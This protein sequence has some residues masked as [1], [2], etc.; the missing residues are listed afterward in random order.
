MPE[1]FRD[2]D[3][4]AVL[5]P[6]AADG[7]RISSACFRR[8][9]PH[10]GL[11]DLRPA[12]EWE[13]SVCSRLPVVEVRHIPLRRVF[14]DHADARTAIAC[15]VDVVGTEVDVIG[16]HVSSKLWYAGPA[17]HL[18]A[19]RPHLPPPGRPA[20]VAGD[21][22]LW[23]P[24]VVALLPGWRRAVVGRTYPANRPHS[25]ID[26]IL[27]NDRFEVLDGRVLHDVGSDHR[28]VV[29]RLRIR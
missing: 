26:H 9:E 17:V 1:A 6:L 3:G 23:G 2:L 24:G 11:G 15:T 8:L 21:C 10:D 29:A 12:G 20:V 16:V 28:P 18:R 13:L 14:R 27:V 4:A 7:Y 25:Q 22:N 19:L 5:E